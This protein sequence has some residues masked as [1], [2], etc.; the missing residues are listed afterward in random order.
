MQGP[1]RFNIDSVALTKASGEATKESKP[2]GHRYCV[3]MRLSTP[4]SI[5]IPRFPLFR[6][7]HLHRVPCSCHYRSVATVMTSSTG[8]TLGTERVLHLLDKLDKPHRR[9][10][11]IHIAGTNSKGTTS[12]ILDSVLSSL[13][14]LT[15]RFNSP[16]L[17]FARDSCRIGGAIVDEQTWDLASQRVHLANESCGAS[18][19]E[20]LFARFLTACALKADLKPQLLIVECGMGGLLDATN[21]FPREAVLASVITP[22]GLDHKSFLGDTLG[23][24]TEHKMGIAKE[25]GLVVV[26]D[27]S[28]ESSAQRRPFLRDVQSAARSKY[29]HLI[30]WSAEA[31]DAQAFGPEESEVLSAIRRIAET[32]RARLVRCESPNAS[33]TSGVMRH[34]MA[35]SGLASPW[36]VLTQYNVVLPP[37][38]QDVHQPS[39]EQASSRNT[40]DR[41]ASLSSTLFTNTTFNASAGQNVLVTPLLPPLPAT[42]VIASAVSTA[43]TTLYAIASDEPRSA[44]QISGSDPHE[45]LRLQLAWNLRETGLMSGDRGVLDS[46]LSNAIA[47][48]IKQWQG[49]GSWVDVTIPEAQN[50]ESSNSME[51]DSQPTRGSKNL[52]VLVD[53]AHNVQALRALSAYLRRIL[54]SHY[55][56]AREGRPRRTLRLAILV[57]LSSSK[58]SDGDLDKILDCIASLPETLDQGGIEQ[59]TDEAL[60]TM[61][62]NLS[63]GEAQ[64]AA[65]QNR[66]N[67][68]VKLDVHFTEFETPVEGM[69]WVHPLKANQLAE[70]FGALADGQ[71]RMF[72]DGS[73]VEGVSSHASLPD[74][75]AQ[76][77][78]RASGKPAEGEEED[79]LCLLTGSLYLVGQLYRYID[80]IA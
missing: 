37:I 73:R 72:G 10:P 19:F 46:G 48:G 33:V 43:L 74:A 58:D 71:S 76:L 57:S 4:A 28:S 17:R 69:P 20:Q 38:L 15:A 52:H 65:A 79:S 29:S 32:K 62:G 53:G 67:V 12:S 9:C 25:G 22:I 45:D 61:T 30:T 2:P 49:R 16:H 40:S 63:L 26:A 50:P 78:Q 35:G 23:A 36:E 31:D 47:F 68:D 54:A 41:I 42:Q 8:I 75:L 80:G 6:S 13:G 34:T 21:I 77:A 14:I 59:V 1:T 24:I 64:S 27:Q 55:G 56:L 70:R 51:V 60:A 7:P 3:C 66:L 39:E 18:E 11:V 5:R 44:R